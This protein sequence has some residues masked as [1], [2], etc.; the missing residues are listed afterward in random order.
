[1]ILRLMFALL[2]WPVIWLAQ[3]RKAGLRGGWFALKCT[4]VGTVSFV[5]GER[6]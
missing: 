5:K 6:A 1:M 3:W 2:F 4:V